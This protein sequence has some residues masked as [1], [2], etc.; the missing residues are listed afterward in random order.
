MSLK[1][2]FIFIIF[3]GLFFPLAL[4][5]GNITGS[6][7]YAWS[8][9]FGYINFENLTVTDS[10]LTGYAWSE[11]AGWINFAPAK[12]GVTNDGSGDLSGYAWGEALG[13]IDFSNVS[14]D[15]STGK[16]SGQATGD[17]V[18]TITFDCS[19]CDIRTDWRVAEE[20]EE[21]E[22]AS[23]SIVTI[24][25]TQPS[26]SPEVPSS[27]I[28]TD[29][30]TQNQDHQDQEE[31]SQDQQAQHHDQE[32]DAVA[33]DLPSSDSAQTQETGEYSEDFSKYIDLGDL[34]FT[35]LIDDDQ[36]EPFFVNTSEGGFYVKNTQNGQIG[37]DIPSGAYRFG[38]IFVKVE[39]EQL[40]QSNSNLISFAKSA[41][42]DVKF[43]LT[44]AGSAFYNIT[45]QN[46]NGNY[47]KSFS[48]PI[49][50]IL[51]IPNELHN[52]GNLGVYW[53]DETK[54][55]W[56]NIPDAQLF[57]DKAVFVV[58]HLTKF[59]IFASR[60][61]SVLQKDFAPILKIEHGSSKLAARQSWIVSV[62]L[63]LSLILFV[64]FVF[65]V[66]PKRNSKFRV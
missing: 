64:V 20:E 28:Q 47:V 34:N 19:N 65:L 14:I 15:S 29:D 39:V 25:N 38:N 31:S 9:N 40:V 51:P 43:D 30:Q 61:E 7:K 42:V 22:T 59:A 2:T 57:Y 33:D 5:A 54:K 13:W 18:G 17:I 6:Y 55:E 24:Y 46:E 58:D 27:G 52:K 3:V 45:A 35:S 16:F 36:N 41:E 56:I 32:E 4:F 10:A 63:G 49:T 66:K 23:S 50:I 12:G 8:D 1:R 11:T 60:D 53:L 44:L 62:F 21:E 48:K 37:I 26:M